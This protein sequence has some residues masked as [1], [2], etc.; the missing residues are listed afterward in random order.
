MSPQFSSAPVPDN[1][2]D[3]SGRYETLVF[4]LAAGAAVVGG[5]LVIYLPFIL[6][7]RHFFHDNLIPATLYGL[8]YDRLFSGD[9]W[10]W[11]A[12]LNGGHPIWVSFGAY[13]IID[14]V[15][16]IVYS[17]AAW[18][19][20]RTIRPPPKWGSLFRLAFMSSQ[21]LIFGVSLSPHDMTSIAKLQAVV[22]EIE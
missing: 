14:P 13:P 4:W 17:A 12:A 15:A 2:A 5:L 11:S 8:F 7:Q 6:G 18:S 9:S 3:H 20:S 1:S 19:W 22:G 21:E 10:L 16:A